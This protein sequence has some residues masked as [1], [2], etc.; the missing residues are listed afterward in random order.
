MV[1]SLINKIAW[2]REGEGGESGVKGGREGRRN[3]ERKKTYSQ[4]PR[5]KYTKFERHIPGASSRVSSFL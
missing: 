4:K 5:R 3:G 2:E 1:V